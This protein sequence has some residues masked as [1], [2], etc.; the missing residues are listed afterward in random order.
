MG[1]GL[2]LALSASAGIATAGDQVGSETALL[3]AA[4]EVM[5]AAGFCTLITLDGTG[6][7][8]ARIMDP[9]PAEADFTVWMATNSGTRK[10][11]QL[12]SDGRA[13]LFFFDP[14]GLGYVTL[15]GTARIIRDPVEEARRWKDEWA[16]FYEDGH[17]GPDFVLIRFEPDRLEVMSIEHE[18]AS[19]PKGWKPAVVQLKSRP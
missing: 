9:F 13:T 2:L 10:V 8:Q 5:E 6:H 19:D 14:E 3:G 15:L 4:R 17:R 18:V 16:D 1:A 12:T 7:L 11:A